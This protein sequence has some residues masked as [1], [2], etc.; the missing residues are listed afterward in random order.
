MGR[1]PLGHH[2][3][4]A[5][6]AR[7]DTVSGVPLLLGHSGRL[8]AQILLRRLDA[9]RD[10]SSNLLALLSQVRALALCLRTR[11]YPLWV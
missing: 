5:L 3:L 7:T 6:P 10:S 2:R 4:P 11:E 8:V 9:A 1:I